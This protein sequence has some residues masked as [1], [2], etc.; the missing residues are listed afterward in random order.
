M[1][2]PEE[3]TPQ[4]VHDALQSLKNDLENFFQQLP[5]GP[6]RK[7]L[8]QI[9]DSLD[10]TLTSLN[11][12]GISANTVA[13]NAAEDSMANPLQQ[14]DNLQTELKAIAGNFAKA[15]DILD[16]TANALSAVSS[17]FGIK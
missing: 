10:D 12:D 11:Q 3:A 7:L 6:D 2:I 5:P 4:Q 13:L 17:Y 8:D 15:A 14:L 1:T 16:K 9:L